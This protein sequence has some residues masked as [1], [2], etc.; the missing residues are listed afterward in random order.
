MRTN[1]AHYEVTARVAARL[2]LPW[3]INMQD[4]NIEVA[5]PTR[6][7]DFLSALAAASEREERICLLDLVLASL[8]EWFEAREPLETIHLDDM[9]QRVSSLAGPTL[10]DFPDVAEYW[11]ENDNPVA[12]LLRRLFADPE[13]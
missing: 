9:A 11:V 12:Q 5:D 2:G 7:D 8:D 4:W 10:R 1:Y 6:I 13:F 3:H